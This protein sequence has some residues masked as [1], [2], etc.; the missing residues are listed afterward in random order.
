MGHL[1]GIDERPAD[2]NGQ[3][4]RDQT[5]LSGRDMV[6]NNVE[7]TPSGDGAG[8]KVRLWYIT[9]GRRSEGEERGRHSCNARPL[10]GTLTGGVLGVSPH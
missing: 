10:R 8:V 7:V 5:G 3:T 6:P 9:T 1:L 2:C 4:A